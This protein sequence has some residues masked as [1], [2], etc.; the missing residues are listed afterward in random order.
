MRVFMFDGAHAIEEKWPQNS[1]DNWIEVIIDLTTHHF[2]PIKNA[3]S[4]MQRCLR[5]MEREAT[6]VAKL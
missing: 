2:N 4:C 5:A 6:S 3:W 1:Y